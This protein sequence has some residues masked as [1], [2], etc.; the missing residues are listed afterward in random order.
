MKH[1]LALTLQIWATVA[2]G[3]DGPRV[4]VQ[5]FDD[6]GKLL[7]TPPGIVVSFAEDPYAEP[8]LTV[9]LPTGGVVKAPHSGNWYINVDASRFSKKYYFRDM[10]L[11][12]EDA[13]QNEIKMHPGGKSEPVGN[14][15]GQ[16]LEGPLFYSDD[17]S[18]Y[19]PMTARRQV[20]RSVQMP[21]GSWRQVTE[22]ITERSLRKVTPLDQGIMEW[23]PCRPL[24]QPLCSPC[25]PCG[26]C[27]P[28]Q[29]FE[30][31]GP[32]MQ[33]QFLSPCSPIQQYPHFKLPSDI[34]QE[35]SGTRS[36]VLID[37]SV[38]F[39]AYR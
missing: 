6:N 20:T 14:P 35:N 8:K 28:P 24:P 25:V 1:A 31:C 12:G 26:P 30:P 32:C 38:S 18:Y 21:D 11:I 13:S 29:F 9:S 19:V 5:F 3:Q 2:F 37:S 23:Q 36:S 33:P 7:A 22:T 16:T 39:G 34:G 15:V 27:Q 10:K 4:L 17:G